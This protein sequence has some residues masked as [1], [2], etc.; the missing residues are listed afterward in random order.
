MSAEG[1]VLVDERVS[2]PRVV[3]GGLRDV[4]KHRC[5]D[6]MQACVDPRVRVRFRSYPIAQE[7]SESNSY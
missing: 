7:G 1:H 2:H 4:L 3:L 5:L 6:G